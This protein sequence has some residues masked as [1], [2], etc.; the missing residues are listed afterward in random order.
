MIE[1]VLRSIG[2][3]GV[4]GVMSISIFFA[5]FTGMLFWATCLNKK[6]VNSMQHLPLE[7]NESD[8]KQ[9]PPLPHE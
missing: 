4:F 8:I 7:D 2:G 6:Y 3:I 9:S 5:F 1:N